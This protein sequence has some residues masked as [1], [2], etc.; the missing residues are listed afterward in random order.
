M[1]YFRIYQEDYADFTV[2]SNYFIDKFMADANDAQ[3]KIYLYLIRMLGADL[4]TGVSEIADRFNYTEKDVTRA[5]NY[6]ARQGIL[7]L[8]LSPTGEITGVRMLSLHSED[9]SDYHPEESDAAIAKA[10]DQK[11]YAPVQTD[12]ASIIDIRD[13]NKPQYTSE[14]LNAFADKPE[15]GQLI[16]VAE[17]YLK[18]QLTQ[19]DITTLLYV[20]DKLHF[21]E[22]LI[23]YLV[24][25]CA[26]KNKDNP[27]YIEK[28]ALDWAESGITTPAQAAMHVSRYDCAYDVMRAL[29]K[30][31]TNPSTVELEY[32]DRWRN[33]FHYDMSIIGVAC[34]RTVLATEK[35]RF[36]YADSILTG[37]YKL[38]VREYADIDRLDPPRKGSASDKGKKNSDGNQFNQFAQNKYD[39]DELEKKL[40]SN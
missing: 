14:E 37:W 31:N 24:Q 19:S 9:T 35:N 26:A 18:R 34:A 36:K 10:G 4:A 22:D 8:D 40:I 16:F 13:Y 38:G 23:D 32:I 2:V 30:N 39:Y 27:R 17:Q 6:W 15:A 33:V 1:G 21:S 20:S 3:L 7:K 11:P 5:L 29:G 25:Y 12:A 28:V